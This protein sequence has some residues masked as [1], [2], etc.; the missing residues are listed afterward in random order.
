MVSDVVDSWERRSGIGD[1]M[2]NIAPH[3]PESATMPFIRVIVPEGLND[4]NALCRELM[5]NAA[6]EIVKK[7]PFSNC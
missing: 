4:R 5:C 1:A 6:I 3:L 7:V 2:V